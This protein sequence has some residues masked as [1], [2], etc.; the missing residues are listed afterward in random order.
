MADASPLRAV[1]FDLDGL[2]FNT[3]ELYPIVGSELLQRRGHTITR[4]L[5]DDMMGRPGRDALQLMIDH[6]TLSDTVEQLSAESDEI[7]VDLLNTRLALMPGLNELLSA[8]ESYRIPKAIATS[9]G[10]GFVTDVLGRFDLE[11]RFEFILTAE[12]VTHGKPNPEIYLTAAQRFGFSPPEVMVLEDSQN[13]CRAAV[14]AG[15]FAVAVPGLYSQEHDFTGARF[16]A[17]S[18]ADPRV[19]EALRIN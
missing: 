12:D 18:L 3:E 1:V 19:Y 13:G 6:H 7:F 9:S 5:L 16:V 2:M 8:L 4:A 17:N 14:A 10:R 11:P 15:T